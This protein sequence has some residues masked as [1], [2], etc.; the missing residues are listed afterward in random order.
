M[1]TL[2]YSLGTLA[3]LS[4]LIGVL[5]AMLGHP[6]FYC[7]SI[8]AA[9]VATICWGLVRTL[10]TERIREAREHVWERRYQEDMKSMDAHWDTTV[11][12]GSE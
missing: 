2:R 6:D 8:I 7:Y 12:G 3:W 9:S 4:I 1:N 10:E 5:G 11:F